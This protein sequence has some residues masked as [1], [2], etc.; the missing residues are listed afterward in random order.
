MYTRDL[1]MEEFK[2]MSKLQMIT[3]IKM[4][5]RFLIEDDIF[6]SRKREIVEVVYRVEPNQIDDIAVDIRDNGYNFKSSTNLPDGTIVR[7]YMKERF[8]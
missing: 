4:D 1:F 7:S 6:S 5:L 8:M 3:E 2:R